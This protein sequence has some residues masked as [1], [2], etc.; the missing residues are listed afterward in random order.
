M[1]AKRILL[2]F[3][4]VSCGLLAGSRSSS[5]RPPQ[6]LPPNIIFILTDDQGWTSLSSRMQ[7]DVSESASD[8]YETPNLD[9]FARA[10]MRFTRGYA[11]AA[12]CSPTRRSIQFGQTPIRQGNEEFPARYKPGGKAPRS[13]PQVLKG[14]DS[15]YKAAH[16]G[17][18]DFRAEILPEQVGYD[19]SDGDTRNGNGNLVQVKGDK[20]DE[21][22]LT[23]DPKKINT[24]TERAIEF[25]QKQT[26]AQ[27]PFYLQLSHYATHVNM[28]TKQA[29][30]DYFTKKKEGKRH[31]NPA[32]AGMLFDLDAGIGEI[33]DQVA[34]LGIA[35][36]TYI[37]MMA[38]NGATEFLPPVKN[39]LDHPSQFKEPMRNYPLRGGK[40]VL[41]EGGIRV[42]FMVMGPGIKAG[43]QSEVPVIGW[44]LLPTFAEL[45]GGTSTLEKDRDGGSFFTLLKNEGKGTVNRPTK[46]FFFHRY[47]TGYPHSAIIAGN[48]KLVRFWKTGKTELYDLAQDRGELTDLA[49]KNPAK[50]KELDARLWNYIKQHN[51]GLLTAYKGNALVKEKPED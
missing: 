28:E 40:W 19:L 42:P 17:K 20:W 9:R 18:W 51:P 11:P 23:E 46:D 48:D 27:V 1:T 43:S 32:W 3:L 15:R 26:S 41:Y 21:H 38:D 49:K 30:L 16:L 25:M 14:I 31:T 12:I 2:L 35:D 22:Y 45:A 5:T 47:N 50:V 13:I 10:G 33:L 24:L 29:T 44:D 8:Y 7:N 37:F 39:R 4:I 36:N 34:K 6:A